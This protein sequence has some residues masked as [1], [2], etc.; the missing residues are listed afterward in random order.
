M[1]INPIA[2][3]LQAPDT[4]H[5]RRSTRC[6]HSQ[7]TPSA[8][9]RRRPA[10]SEPAWQSDR[11]RKSPGRKAIN[12]ADI[13]KE[14]VSTAKGAAAAMANSTVPSGVPS[15]VSVIRAPAWI[16]P[17]ARMRASGSTSAGTIPDQAPL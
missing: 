6:R 4:T 9:S 13:A 7:R 1:A 5:S 12:R 14:T 2:T 15:R 17:L 3:R 16:A 8:A 10:T 11:G